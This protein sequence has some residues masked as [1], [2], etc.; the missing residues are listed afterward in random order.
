MD[1]LMKSQPLVSVVISNYNYAIYLKQCIESVL[2][3]TYSNLEIILVDDGSNDN[4]LEVARQFEDKI[5]I[6]SQTNLG[7]NAARNNGIKEAVGEFIAICDSDDYWVNNKIEKQMELFFKNPDLV[8][9]YCSY[10]RTN[11][12]SERIGEI[13]AAHSGYLAD[14]FIE[15]PMQALVA[16]GCSTALFKKRINQMYVFFDESLRGNGE[17][18]DFF[19]R[20]SKYG[21]CSYVSAPLSH[22]REHDR[23]R[24]GRQL[25]IFYKGNQAAINRALTD[26]D[27]EWTNWLAFIFLFKFELMMA[28]SYLKRGRLILA[29]SHLIKAF[30]SQTSNQALKT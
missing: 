21:N 3:Q 14:L 28:K 17:D 30:L 25:S 4:S 9:V 18:W 16:G 27:Y 7:V 1:K 13:A 15:R 12:R 22:I 2:S 23:S 6:V 26:K 5:K 29:L 11:E 19:R 10:F 24:S 8:L 20:I